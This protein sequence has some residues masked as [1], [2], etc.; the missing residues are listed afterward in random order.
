MS[1][2]NRGQENHFSTLSFKCQE[3]PLSYYLAYFAFC[4]LSLC[5]LHNEAQFYLIL[6]K[7]RISILNQ[8]LHLFSGKNNKLL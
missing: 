3:D 6:N 5:D 7:L 8:Q 2:G 1:T 4:L